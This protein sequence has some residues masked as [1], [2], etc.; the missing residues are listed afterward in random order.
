[1]DYEP[2]HP[3]WAESYPLL[4]R[5]ARISAHLNRASGMTDSYAATEVIS[6]ADTHTH[7]LANLSQ[8]L[9]CPVH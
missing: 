2:F 5:L 4:L 3:T 7:H 9:G 6:M 1:M 8:L